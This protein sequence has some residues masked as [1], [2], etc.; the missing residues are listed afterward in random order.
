MAASTPLLILLIVVTLLAS[1]KS[2]QRSI[3][4]ETFRHRTLNMGFF[5]AMAKAMANDPSLPPAVN[6][7]LR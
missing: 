5:D 6:P 1:V 4:R 2:F 3:K 7:G